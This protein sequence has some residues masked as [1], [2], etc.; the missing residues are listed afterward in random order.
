MLVLVKKSFFIV[1][2]PVQHVGDIIEL[3]DEHAKVLI[4]NNVVEEV[5]NQEPVEEETLNVVKYEELNLTQL[6][7]LLKERGLSTKG[8]KSE[9]IKRL[10]ESDEE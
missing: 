3:D 9:L 7:D 1:G 6:K 10:K 5:K 8:K 4:K 2:E